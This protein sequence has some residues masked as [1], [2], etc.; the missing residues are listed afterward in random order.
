[1]T[2]M[3]LE[4]HLHHILATILLILCLSIRLWADKLLNSCCSKPEIKTAS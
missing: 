1:M 4:M 2:N 3:I